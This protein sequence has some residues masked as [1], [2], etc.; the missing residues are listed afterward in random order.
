MRPA[1]G[2]ATQATGETSAHAECW[3]EA[4]RLRREHRRWIVIWLA[5]DNC[6]RAC[7]RT[8]GSRRDTALSAPTAHDMAQQI[9][10]ADQAAAR[11]A[12]H[13]SDPA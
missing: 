7:R 2:S 12:L 10:Q 3:R 1:P 8:P 9:S 5:R 11:P 13:A 4:A 6:F